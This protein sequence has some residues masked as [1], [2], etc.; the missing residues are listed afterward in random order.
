VEA[1]IVLHQRG[2]ERVADA[3]ADRAGGEIDLRLV[4]GARGIGLRA[5]KCPEI[6][7]CLAALAAKKILDRVKDRRRVR[8]DREPVLGPQRMKIERRQHRRRRGAAR[9]VA[10][11]LEPVAVLAQMVGLVNGPGREPQHLALERAQERDPVGR[12]CRREAGGGNGHGGA[13]LAHDRPRSH[14]FSDHSAVP[15]AAR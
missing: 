9:L 13:S 2:E 15:R 11:D 6:G 3:Q 14:V 8:L 5:A 1:D 12:G 10:A 7:Q 4:L